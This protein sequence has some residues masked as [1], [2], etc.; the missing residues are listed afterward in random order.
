MYIYNSRYVVDEIRAE[1]PR[2]RTRL[3]KS[4]RDKTTVG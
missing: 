3:S 1:V 2:F 4:V